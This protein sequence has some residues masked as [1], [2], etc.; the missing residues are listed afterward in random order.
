MWRTHPLTDS[1]TKRN[2][3]IIAA[4]APEALCFAV[5]WLHSSNTTP[6]RHVGVDVSFVYVATTGGKVLPRRSFW[7]TSLWWLDMFPRWFQSNLILAVVFMWR[8]ILTALGCTHRRLAPCRAWRSP[9]A[10]RAPSQESW[11]AYAVC[12]AAGVYVWQSPK[13]L[14]REC[15]CFCCAHFRPLHLPCVAIVLP[16]AVY[17]VLLSRKRMWQ[18]LACTVFG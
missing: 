10:G 2:T 17:W 4:G 13:R 7:G 11:S 5:W 6:S 9:S 14:C 3:L 18:R 1:Q 8:P 16:I 12:C 15:C